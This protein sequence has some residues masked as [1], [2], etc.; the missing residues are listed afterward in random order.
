MFSFFIFHLL[1]PLFPSSFR[2]S[3]VSQCGRRLYSPFSFVPWLAIAAPFHALSYTNMAYPSSP[4]DF[5]LLYWTLLTVLYHVFPYSTILPHARSYN[6]TPCG[7]VPTFL[8]L[9]I[10]TIH[11]TQCLTNCW[12]FHYDIFLSDNIVGSVQVW[13]RLSRG[14]RDR[15]DKWRNWRKKW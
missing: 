7:T 10:I 1:S 2:P 11:L 4:T 5:S 6:I 9:S 8:M 15:D 3:F 14:Y 12:L 13:R